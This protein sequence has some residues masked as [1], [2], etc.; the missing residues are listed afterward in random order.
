MKTIALAL[1]LAFAITACGEPLDGS[2]T[3]DLEGDATTVE[4]GA[5]DGTAYEPGEDGLLQSDVV[6]E[7]DEIAPRTEE[8]LDDDL[9]EAE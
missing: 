7:A 4:G 2:D 1:P 9:T 3:A 6:P 5:D 8:Q